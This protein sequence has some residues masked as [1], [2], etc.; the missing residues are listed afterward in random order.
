MSR[1]KSAIVFAASA[2]FAAACVWGAYHSAEMSAAAAVYHRVK[3]GFF[4]GSRFEVPPVTDGA[5]ASR[6]CRVAARFCP[7][8][9]R[10]PVYAAARCLDEAV[11]ESTPDGRWQA[12]LADANEWAGR[13]LALCPY[14]FE[15]RYNRAETLVAMDRLPDAIAYWETVLDLEFWNPENHDEYAYLLL[16]DGSEEAV[17]KAVDERFFV[18]DRELRADLNKLWRERKKAA[19]EA[20]KARKKA[21]AEAEKARKKAEAEAAKAAA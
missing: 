4:P 5:E 12:A 8:D 14:D 10:F 7:Y 9:W 18:R 19:A 3:H 20:E 13:A 17:A 6:L 2:V 15:V 11:D 16:H 1:A 21:A